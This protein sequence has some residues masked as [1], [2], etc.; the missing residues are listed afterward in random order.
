MRKE[1]TLHSEFMTYYEDIANIAHGAFRHLPEVEREEA[2]AEV[3]AGAWQTFLRYREK[4]SPNASFLTHFPIQ[5]FR[6]NKKFTGCDSRDIMSGMKAAQRR[7]SRTNWR[8]CNPT[9]IAGTVREDPAEYA[10]VKIDFN[11][12]AARLTLK[13]RKVF[14][15]RLRG[16]NSSEIGRKLG[17]GPNAIWQRMKKIRMRLSESVEEYISAH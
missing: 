15:L 6:A 2:V 13:E 7:P 5:S 4:A 11:A 16:Y 3:F 12:F 9:E 10:R 1:E 17:V 8:T 14:F